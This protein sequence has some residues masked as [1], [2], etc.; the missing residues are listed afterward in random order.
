MG[1]TKTPVS[2]NETK[3]KSKVDRLFD[4][5]IEPSDI[6]QGQLGMTIIFIIIIIIVHSFIN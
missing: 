4:G 2:D 3:A 5:N 6:C 1:I